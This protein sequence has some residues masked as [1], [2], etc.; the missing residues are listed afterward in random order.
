MSLTTSLSDIQ[1][2]LRITIR[3]I[4]ICLTWLTLETAL[5]VAAE[6]PYLEWT[7]EQRTSAHDAAIDIA[8]DSLGS[9]FVTGGTS[10]PLSGSSLGGGGCLP[11]SV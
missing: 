4:A 8:A 10:G 6:P 2:P 3:L 7:R 11:H 5:A 1:S 9:I